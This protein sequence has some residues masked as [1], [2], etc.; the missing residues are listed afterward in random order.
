M[1]RDDLA[2]QDDSQPSYSFRPSTFGAPRDFRLSDRAIAWEIGRRS[3]SIAFDRIDRVRLSFRPATL[4]S[5]R[6]VTEIWSAGTPRLDIASS[7]WKS[8]VE[9]VDQG[10][11]YRAFVAEL[12]RRLAVSA[13]DTRFDAGIHPMLYW[14]GLAAF[15]AAAVGFAGLTIRALQSD[16]GVAALLIFAFLLLFL[17]Q[18]GNIFYRNRPARYRP[19]ALPAALLPRQKRTTTD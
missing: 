15:I 19:D 4:Q 6:F 2:M 8:M 18:A 12:H 13:R 9:Q 7:S 3:G 17:W 1:M 14:P 5:R 11:A 10:D 16:A